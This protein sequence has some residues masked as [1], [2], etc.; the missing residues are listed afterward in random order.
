MGKKIDTIEK[1][2]M[3]VL[4]AYSWPGNIRE[5]QNVIERSIIGCETDV[6]VVDPSWISSDASSSKID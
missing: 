5:L 4:E 1:R 6:F 3:D 2:T